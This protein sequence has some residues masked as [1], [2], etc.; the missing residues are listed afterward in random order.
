MKYT[1]L[2]TL[3]LSKYFSLKNIVGEGYLSSHELFDK[4]AMVYCIPEKQAEALFEIS[5]RD[6]ISSITRYEDYLVD[7]RALD[8]QDRFGESVSLAEDVMFALNCKGQGLRV[9]REFS[10]TCGKYPAGSK[11]KTC[12]LSQKL[13]NNIHVAFATAFLSISSFAS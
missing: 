12:L 1:F 11:L 6:E 2:E 8:Y 7:M 3:M 13:T 9:M 5:E 4:L 10:Q